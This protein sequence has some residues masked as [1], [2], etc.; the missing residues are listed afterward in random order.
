[1]KT[2]APLVGVSLLVGCGIT[3]WKDKGQLGS[4][5]ASDTQAR[6]YYRTVNSIGMSNPQD[7][8]ALAG[9]SGA[10]HSTFSFHADLDNY[11]GRCTFISQWPKHGTTDTFSTYEP[12]FD[13]YLVSINPIVVVGVE[14]QNPQMSAL[15]RMDTWD[16]ESIWSSYLLNPIAIRTKAPYYRSANVVWFSPA[17]DGD[18]HHLDMTSSA[19]SFKITKDDQITVVVDGAQLTTSRKRQD[20]F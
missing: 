4:W 14:R 12:P 9:K 7:E 11:F 8:I 2:F 6:V 5:C 1:M 15:G 17:V 16:C 19:A 20:K 3:A 10:K 13:F 18:L